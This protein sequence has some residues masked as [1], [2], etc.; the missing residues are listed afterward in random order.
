MADNIQF[1]PPPPVPV[2]IDLPGLPHGNILAL[3]LGNESQGNNYWAVLGVERASILNGDIT[4]YGNCLLFVIGDL[5]LTWTRMII[6]YE[7]RLVTMAQLAKVP[8]PPYLRKVR[9]QPYPDE[10]EMVTMEVPGL[11][12]T[13][14][15]W[16]PL[17]KYTITFRG[18][19]CPL[20]T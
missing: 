13:D 16:T 7:G 8:D 19:W 12:I 11:L 9:M 5:T 20:F 6:P 1:V 14:V 3:K 17:S 10:P 18:D 15:S 2:F 4:Y